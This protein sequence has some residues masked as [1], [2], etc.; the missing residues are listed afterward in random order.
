MTPPPRVLILT[1]AIG[2]GHDA[3][4]RRLEEGLRERAPDA[5]VV[6]EDGLRA[7]GRVL[8]R[9]ILGG[10]D[11]HTAWGNL[12]FELSYRLLHHVP[13]T[14]RLGSWLLWA[15]GGRGLRRLIR[16]QRPDVVVST[17]PAVTEVL[18][19]LRARGRLDVPVASVIT[20]LAG[21]RY[22]SHAGID[23]HLVT[24]PESVEEVRA[25]AG[26]TTAVTAVSGLSDP[27]FLVPRE[28]EHARAALELPAG[29]KVVV[30]SGGGWG[31]GDVVG[32]IE[33]VLGLDATLALVLCG[34]NETLRASVDARFAD[35]ERVRALGFTDRMPD[36]L[37]AADALVHATAGLTVLEA[38]V[39]GCPTISYGW[40]RGHI[41]ANNRAFLRF[42]LAD[43]ATGRRELRAS[44]ERAL[45]ARRPP[46]ASLAAL[47]SAAAVVLDRFPPL[48][49]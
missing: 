24:H 13:P 1:A 41:R 49:P 35:R 46:D 18:G 22:W 43:V 28:Q 3:P 21:L 19:R 34:H 2:A 11:F 8:E 15:F 9:A 26:R 44:L 4:A 48:G 7:M 30:I 10:S 47:P 42:G 5:R 37:A 25:V 23:L 31:V 6:V 39:R 38:L 36:V 12:M 17:Y 14:R 27:A 16:G 29:G 45:Q 40:G 20:D 32:A 33:E